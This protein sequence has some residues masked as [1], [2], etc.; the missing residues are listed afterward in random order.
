MH[1]ALRPR[2]DAACLGAPILKYVRGMLQTPCCRGDAVVPPS[3]PGKGAV[4]PRCGRPT[5][6]GDT[7]EPM[8]HTLAQLAQFGLDAEARPLLKSRDEER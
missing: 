7:T 8:L 2:P 6:S 5:P 4:C 1:D 3:A